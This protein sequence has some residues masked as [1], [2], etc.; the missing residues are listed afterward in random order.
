MNADNERGRLIA[1]KAKLEAYI[2]E[3]RQRKNARELEIIR[4][5]FEPRD[6]FRLRRE[7]ELEARQA[8]TPARERLAE[9]VARL[10]EL[11]PKGNENPQ[12]ETLRAI[13]ETLV[14]IKDFI[15]SMDSIGG[16]R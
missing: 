10:Q 12:A 14:E 4:K 2:G 16:D 13:L 9:I 11:K 7:I 6:D 15:T 5:Q 8:A 1:E 3:I